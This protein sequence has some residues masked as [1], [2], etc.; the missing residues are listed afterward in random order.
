MNSC[1]NQSHVLVNLVTLSFYSIPYCI[2][3]SYARHCNNVARRSDRFKKGDD[4]QKGMT[5][6][7]LVNFDVSATLNFKTS[8]NFLLQLQ[9]TLQMQEEWDSILYISKIKKN[10]YYM[11]SNMV[12]KFDMMRK[13]F[14]TALTLNTPRGSLPGPSRATF[15]GINYRNVSWIWE[16]E[17]IHTLLLSWYWN[18]LSFLG[19]SFLEFFDIPDVGEWRNRRFFNS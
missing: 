12:F 2:L 16:L 14:T 15:G 3:S 9:F 8:K 11:R 4:G 10:I 18:Q 13:T 6:Y 17:R 19:I 1:L 7:Q 5:S